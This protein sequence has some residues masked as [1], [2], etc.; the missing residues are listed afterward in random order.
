MALTR[1]YYY[2]NFLIRL[3][4]VIIKIHIKFVEMQKRVAILNL[5]TCILILHYM[6]T[7]FTWNLNKSIGWG[8]T[9][10]DYY[11]VVLLMTLFVATI[12]TVVSIIRFRCSAL[13]LISLVSVTLSLFLV[14]SIIFSILKQWFGK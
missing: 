3:I 11:G 8:W 2:F 13:N 1:I 4:V 10:F 5:I 9:W 12:F 6:S 7:P 14:G